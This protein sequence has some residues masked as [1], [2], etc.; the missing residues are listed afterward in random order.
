MGDRCLPAKLL[1]LPAALAFTALVA[2]TV[3]AAA[4]PLFGYHTAIITGG[5]MDPTIGVG[6]L[7]VSRSAPPESLQVGDIITFRRPEAAV[8]VTLCIRR[9]D[10]WATDL[11]PAVSANSQ[12][13]FRG[14][15][16]QVG[17]RERVNTV[18]YPASIV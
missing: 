14:A 13:H 15:R 1:V 7:V 12:R 4:L 8:D 6:A 10:V 5:S 3:A 2:L 17:R 9:S 18:V 11:L 16:H